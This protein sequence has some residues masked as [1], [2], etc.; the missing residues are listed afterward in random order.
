M[1]QKGKE[2]T[3]D[4]VLQMNEISVGAEKVAQTME[5]LE[6]KSTEINK[7][8]EVITGIATETNLL[9]LNA[10]IEAARA[11]DAGKGFAVVAEQ[12]RK[13]AEDS[14]QAADQINDLIKGD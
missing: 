6:K 11:G 5:S 12:V 3:D 10:A 8:V 1:A 14:K 7:I 4:L 2:L 13:L 9:A